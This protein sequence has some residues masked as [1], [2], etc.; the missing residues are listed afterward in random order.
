MSRWGG[1]IG[2]LAEWLALLWWAFG[3]WCMRWLA[4]LWCSGRAC[5][6]LSYVPCALH[7][8]PASLPTKC[9]GPAHLISVQRACHL[10]PPWLDPQPAFIHPAPSSAPP[11]PP[12][13]PGPALGARN[14]MHGRKFG[15]R[16]VEAV[17]M[18][19]QDYTQFKWD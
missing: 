2:C 9:I 10:L 7:L 19:D 3:G 5:R 6:L 18:G 17:L 8:R 4:L 15:G 13:E 1:R 12:A 16:V 11:T 14:A